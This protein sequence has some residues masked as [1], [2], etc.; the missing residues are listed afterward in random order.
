[1]KYTK[2]EKEKAL[3][4]YEEVGSVKK[5]IQ[6]LGYPSREYFYQWL[7]D[8]KNPKPKIKAPRKRIN[9]SPEHPLHPSPELKL[10]TIQRCFE[11]G[12]NVKLVSEEIGYSRSMIYTWKRLYDKK[13]A[14]AFMGYQDIPRKKMEEPSAT[15]EEIAELK[16]LM[17]KMQLKI[18]VLEETIKVIKKDHGVD[19]KTLK[20]KEKATIIDALKNEY[21]LPELLDVMEIAK[22]SYYYVKTPKIDKHLKLRI[23]IREIFEENRCS[24]GYR[25][26]HAILLRKNICVSEK[27]I[28]RLMEEENLQVKVKR[29][30]K[31]NSYKGE[32][33]PAV[34]NVVA[35]DFHADKPNEKWL[36]DLTE[37]AIPAGKVYLSPIV[38]C[39]DGFIPSWTIGTNPNAN[40]VNG[41][42]LQGINKLKPNEKP[43]LHTDRGCHYRWPSW[44][45]I[46]EKFGLT[47]SMSA[48]GCSPDNS[49]CEGFF[50]R[51]KN[52]FFYG[53][54][55]ADYSIDDFIS[56]LNDYI[57]WYN[58]VRIK[59]SLGFLS[60]L[61]Y[62]QKIGLIA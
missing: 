57:I 36:S 22:S 1:M 7:R 3:K 11:R 47:R 43:I 10:E 55:W 48:K 5:V 20:N 6:K 61:E 39:F 31:Y 44:I 4:L 37:F 38:D 13:G 25:R 15:S 12:E 23:T 30:R 16:A 18:N 24:Y 41:M 60:P 19:L 42:L 32:I 17:R 21:S 27:V 52:E 54:D 28:R 56:A 49:A 2:E 35:R 58:E 33:T 9:N 8:A 29:T 50:G 51:L 62:R 14:A 45:D 46:T 53:R 26:I 34:E 59:K 40:L